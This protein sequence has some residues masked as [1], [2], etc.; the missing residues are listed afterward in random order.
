[1][2]NFSRFTEQLEVKNILSKSC[3]HFLITE[4]ISI[5]VGARTNE[6]LKFES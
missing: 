5:G 4:C 2:I 6:G 1:M 3:I